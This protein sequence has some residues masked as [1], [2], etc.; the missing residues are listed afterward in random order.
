MFWGLIAVTKSL[1]HFFPRFCFQDLM[2]L[3]TSHR[4]HGQHED[5]EIMV[6]I[7]LQMPN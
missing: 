4:L 5:S 7:G 1:S 6:D 2:S 3:M